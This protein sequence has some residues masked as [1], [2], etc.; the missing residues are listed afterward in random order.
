MEPTDWWAGKSGEAYTQRNRVDWRKREMFWAGMLAS[1]STIRSLY[2]VGCNAGWN[3][4]AIEAVRRDVKCSGC[5]VN[6]TAVA[7]AKAAGLN[8]ICGPAIQCLSKYPTYDLVF[9]SGGL[10]KYP[11]Y[12]LVFTSGVLIQRGKALLRSEFRSIYQYIGRPQNLLINSSSRHRIDS[13]PPGSPC[14]PQRPNNCRSM[15]CAS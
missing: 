8:V 2:E 12:D 4:S 15:R 14:R 5:D 7:Q 6:S 13:W 10:S 9:T 3:L 1:M 11:I